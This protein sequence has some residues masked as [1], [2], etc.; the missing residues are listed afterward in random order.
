MTDQTE[1][2]ERRIVVGVDGSPG[3]LIALRWAVTQA[4]LSNA[5]V[6]VVA[7]W[8]DPAEYAFAYG[9]SAAV[10]EDVSI[11]AITGKMLTEA[12]ADVARGGVPVQ[13]TT[14]VVR[15]HPAQA[16][17]DAADRAQLLVV[18][19]RGHGAFAGMLLGSVSQH[20]VQHAPCPVVVVP[21]AERTFDEAWSDPGES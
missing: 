6:D 21:W 11:A 12:V 1:E 10:F 7:A 5:R 13:F 17:L 4:E 15:G 18:G 16:L 2:R 8:H 19:S 9:W 20:C 3:S 14:H